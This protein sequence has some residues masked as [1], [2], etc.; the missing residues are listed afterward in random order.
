MAI[1]IDWITK[2][3][4]IPQSYL[5]SLGGGY[6]QLDVDAFRLDL[7]TIE[8]DEGMVYPDTHRH[9][10]QV[11]LAGTVYVGTVEFINGYT[12]NFEDVG[13]PYTVKCVGANHN[14]AD[15]KV[16]NQVSLIIGNA[17]G[18]I[19]A[20]TGVSGLTTAESNKLMGLDA[21]TATAVW[22]KPEAVK[23]KANTSLIPGLL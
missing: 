17:A 22:A 4:T 8:D 9:N 3:I 12:I 6:Y 11:T 2:V 1:T 19:I 5:G 7:K 15:V 20:E 23:V 14:I 18:L 13:S 16:V 21:E 10:S